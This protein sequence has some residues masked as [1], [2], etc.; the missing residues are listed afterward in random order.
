[1]A[2]PE[3]HCKFVENPTL[4]IFLLG[5]CNACNLQRDYLV[6]RTATN[7]IHLCP[8]IMLRT[9]LL[10]PAMATVTVFD[11]SSAAPVVTGKDDGI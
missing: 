9:N 6:G 8:T 11:Q 2:I 4:L 10:S 1:M 7:V 5:R 3:N